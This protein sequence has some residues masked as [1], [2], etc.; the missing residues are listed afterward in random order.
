MQLGADAVIRGAGRSS[1]ARAALMIEQAHRVQGTNFD[2]IV[3]D[4]AGESGPAL[5]TGE[6]ADKIFVNDANGGRSLNKISR[7][8]AR[9]LRWRAA[10]LDYVGQFMSQ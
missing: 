2:P 3:P 10:L 9:R 7:H 4:R 8:R 6:R 5:F 1:Q